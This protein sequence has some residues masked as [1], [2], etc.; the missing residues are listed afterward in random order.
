MTSCCLTTTTIH[1]AVAAGA[2]AAAVW[3][4]CCL[5]MLIH[6]S[7]ESIR[8]VETAEDS[9]CCCNRHPPTKS[10]WSP[11]V[12]IYGCPAD[13]SCNC[14]PDGRYI[15]AA[16]RPSP[17]ST[18]ASAGCSSCVILFQASSLQQQRLR[19]CREQCCAIHYNLTRLS[20]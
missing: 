18:L 10:L 12:R 14:L 6:L 1:V 16:D 2:A 17:S 9:C 11:F 8:Q 19:P 4:C 5:L 3:W 7:L 13:V 15:P 20:S